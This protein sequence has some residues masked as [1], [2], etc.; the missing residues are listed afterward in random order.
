MSRVNKLLAGVVLTCA[1]FTVAAAPKVNCQ[2]A[3]D[4][5]VFMFGQ[6][7]RGDTIEDLYD[8][9]K[10]S[11][12]TRTEQVLTIF[13]AHQAEKDYK[14]ELAPT[15]TERSSILRDRVMA[16][17]IGGHIDDALARQGYK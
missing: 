4:L 16:M 14:A 15:F 12:F 3:A 6:M 17:C 2:D 13:L 5:S 7:A 11:G 9:I 8:V 10:T 1:A